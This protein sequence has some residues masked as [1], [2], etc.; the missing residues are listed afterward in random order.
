MRA[1]GQT[2]LSS[3]IYLDLE[4]SVGAGE[5]SRHDSIVALTYYRC[6]G[7][8]ISLRISYA[9]TYCELLSGEKWHGQNEQ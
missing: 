1:R 5:T 4:R 7:Q 9:T 3:S 6:A 2:E 8:D